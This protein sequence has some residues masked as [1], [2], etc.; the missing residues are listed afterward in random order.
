MGLIEEIHE[1]RR[2]LEK[3]EQQYSNKTSPCSRTKCAF[4]RDNEQS[5]NCSW[6][7]LVEECKDYIPTEN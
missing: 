6:T 5:G 7:V 4:Y 1:K 2:E 3:L